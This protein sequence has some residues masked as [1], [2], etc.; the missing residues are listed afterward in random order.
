MGLEPQKDCYQL[1]GQQ[2]AHRVGL[3]KDCYRRLVVVPRVAHQVELQK[4]H[5]LLLVG[6]QVGLRKG[7]WHLVVELG[8]RIEVELGHRIV[9]ELQRVAFLGMC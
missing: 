2:E 8:H 3:Q 4:V 9:V 6:Q 7:C 1:V 5:C